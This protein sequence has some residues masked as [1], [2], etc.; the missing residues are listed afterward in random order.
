M[1][2]SLN[3]LNK[4]VEVADLDPNDIAEKLT[5][6]GL[7]VDAVE[8]LAPLDNVVVAKVKSCVKHPDADKLSLCEVFDGTETYQVVCGAPNVAEG[9]TIVFAKIGAVLPGNFKIKKAKIRGTESSGMICAED[10]IGL[11]E[12]HDGIM[13]LDD[14]L[15]PGM[16]VNEL[17]GL[18][19]TVLEIGITPNRADC[20]SII[21]YAHE[22]AALY[23]RKLKKNEYKLNETDEPA[24]NYGGV[25]IKNKKACPTYLGRVIKDVT[26]KPSP[27]WM[28]NRLRA[29]GVR[30]ISNVV[31]ITNYVLFEYGQPLHTFDLKEI[32]GRIIIRNAE[33]GEKLITLDEKE[34]VFN[35]NMLLITDEKKSLAIAGV[36]GGEHSG[37]SKDTKDVFLE[38]AYFEP[39]QTRMTARKLGMQTDASYRYERGIDP[40]NTK[41]MCEYAAYLIQE[42]CG[43]KVCKGVLGEVNDPEPITFTVNADWIN[44]YLGTDVSLDQMV[45]ILDGLNM[46]PVV[47]SRDIT[48]TSP[49]YRVDIITRQDIAEEIAR[50]YGYNNIPTTLPK[51]DADSMPMQPLLATRRFLAQKLKTLGFNEAIN[52]SFMKADFL[53]LFDSEE[54]FVKLINPIS[55]DMNTMRT[56][57]FPGLLATIR[58][59]LNNG[60]KQARFFE[61]ASSFIKTEDKLPEQRM[62]LAAASAGDFWDVSW[63]APK[64]TEPFFMMKGV[65]EN[66]LA[67][68]KIKAEFTKS[69]RHFLHPG[70]S[71]EVIVNGKSIGFIGELHPLT[72]EAA[73]LRERVTFFEIDMQDFVDNAEFVFKFESFSKF[74]SVYKDI[75]VIV[76]TDTPTEKLTEC[77]KNT[78]K[79]AEDVSLYDV[80]TG[81]G[82][83]E[84]KASRTF[85]VLFTAGD[86]TLTDEET[87][88]ILQKMIDNLV[89]DYGAQL[90]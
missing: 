83:E 38:C 15:E 45:Q 9:Q 20:L 65:L 3:W 43:G 31:D 80:Y 76:D 47:N 21:G 81:K 63:A 7:E 66:L 61:F 30:P 42:L 1:K 12:N 60:F 53:K 71:A 57:V 67:Q 28:Q 25:E 32:D 82:I 33:N 34:R 54:K 85:R 2:V 17:F 26:I 86:R 24:G 36:M 14:S 75:S 70:K 50:M 89:K 59:N 69:S 37:I 90:R 40:V 84:G 16:P 22:I 49:S 19:D 39:K 5:M 23:N 41:E 52:Y 73:E 78:S 13:V 58:Y 11:S 18:P 88:G 72:A 10:E 79:L 74:P 29:V 44:S 48:I 6:C 77:I 62:L 68:Y 35:E 64:G 4:F 27:L 87:N 8:H 55:E 56:Q 46:N 51:I